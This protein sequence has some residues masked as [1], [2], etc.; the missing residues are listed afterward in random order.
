[1]VRWAPVQNTVG[2]PAYDPSTPQFFTRYV[3]ANKPKMQNYTY[4]TGEVDEPTCHLGQMDIERLNRELN[5]ACLYDRRHDLLSAHINLDMLI[6]HINYKVML[7]WGQEGAKPLHSRTRNNPGY[8]TI[9]EKEDNKPIYDTLQK[10]YNGAMNF[11]EMY[12]RNMHV[13]EYGEA[14]H[15]YRVVGILSQNPQLIRNR[16]YGRIL[17]NNL[18]GRDLERQREK[19]DLTGAYRHAV[20]VFAEKSGDTLINSVLVDHIHDK[21][22]KELKLKNVD[23]TDIFN[24]LTQMPRFRSRADLFD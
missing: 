10:Q 12:R 3:I 14:Q 4:V 16:I 6:V 8:L 2:S 13:D 24:I 15:A 7:Y 19:G 1:M 21:L 17:N 20:V 11:A 23:K 5:R 9:F 18:H 22:C